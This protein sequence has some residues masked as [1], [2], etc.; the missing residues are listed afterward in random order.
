[1]RMRLL[2]IWISMTALL[3]WSRAQED[4]IQEV[5][6]S[7]AEEGERPEKNEESPSFMGTTDM[8]AVDKEPVE[9]SIIQQNIPFEGEM[10]HH[11]GETNMDA[12]DKPS[13]GASLDDPKPEEDK[14][15]PEK[16]VTSTSPP[17]ETSESDKETETSDHSDPSSQI[18]T[19]S[20]EP[21]LEADPEMPKKPMEESHSANETAE[22]S[23]GG[24]PD[25]QGDG[26][27]HQDHTTAPTTPGTLTP[28]TPP[29]PNPVFSMLSCYSC[30]FCNNIT[31]ELPKANCPPIPGK[32]NGCRTILVRDPNVTPDKKIYI[33]RGCISE[34]D[35]LSVYCDKNKELC[36]TCYE[37]HCNV[38]NMTQFEQSLGSAAAAHHLVAPL[39]IWSI[40]LF[41]WQVLY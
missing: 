28:A 22:I 15:E 12:E 26:P 36:P 13:E 1:M 35:T 25:Y 37:N 32:N 5:S 2:V 20:E 8:P 40:Y 24:S 39:L 9:T 11:S 34:L 21:S 4:N 6:L 27:G 14:K 7:V 3:Q 41:S 29:I 30:M 19:V 17:P 31:K 16:E 10:E 33:S 18:P 38:H 23:T